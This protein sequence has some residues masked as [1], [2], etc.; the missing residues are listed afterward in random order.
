M[1][2]VFASQDP[3]NYA[4]ETRSVRLLGAVT[5][6]RLEAKFWAVIDE[7]AVTQSM[8]T[9]QFLNK[10]YE[11]VIDIRG[12]VPNFASLLRCCCLN[13]LAPDF[14]KN[15]LLREAKAAHQ[16]LAA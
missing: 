14:D 7:I 16:N 13:Y 1:C 15:R 9:P 6:V 10:L 3:K 8:T 2:H 5:S 12:E 11:E 4:Y